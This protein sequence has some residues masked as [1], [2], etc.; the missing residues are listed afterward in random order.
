MRPIDELM[1]D[2]AKAAS[3]GKDH[4]LISRAELRQLKDYEM[5]VGTTNP[6]IA[7]LVGDTTGVRLHVKD[8]LP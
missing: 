5:V 7:E 3:A 6:D 1:R 2:V 4:I 8:V